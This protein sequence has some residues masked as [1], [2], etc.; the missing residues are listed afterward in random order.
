[1]ATTGGDTL[2][3][4]FVQE[5]FVALSGDESTEEFSPDDDTAGRSASGNEESDAAGP[6]TSTDVNASAKKRKRR[7]KEKER[8]VKLGLLLPCIY[9][10]LYILTIKSKWNRNVA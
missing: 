9:F 3:D 6:S 5:D 4:D 7:E 10:C 1:M 8:K 2:E